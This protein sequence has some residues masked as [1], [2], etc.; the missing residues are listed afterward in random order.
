MMTVAKKMATATEISGH[1]E[2]ALLHHKIMLS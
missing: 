2:A 1:Q